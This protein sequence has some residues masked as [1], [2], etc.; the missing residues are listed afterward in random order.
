MVSVEQ[1]NDYQPKKTVKNADEKSVELSFEAMKIEY[2]ALRGRSG[3]LDNKVYILLT[4]CAFLFTSFQSILEKFSHETMPCAS[5]EAFFLTVVSLTVLLLGTL[6]VLLLLLLKPAEYKWLYPYEILKKDI[7]MLEKEYVTRFLCGRYQQSW[8]NNKELLDKRYR[9][10]NWC[11]F[12]VI[13]VIILLFI[14]MLFMYFKP[15]KEVQ[16]YV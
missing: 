3:K 2:E 13:C 10:L 11:V 1:L 6:L 12:C 9:K 8:N 14:L 4:A 15:V 7:F 16:I 5:F